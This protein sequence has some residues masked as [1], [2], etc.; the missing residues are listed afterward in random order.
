[1]PWVR[2]RSPAHL[3]PRVGVVRDGHIYAMAGVHDLTDLFGR[4]PEAER[5][6]LTRPSEVVPLAEPRL[7]P[8]LGRP[9]SIRDFYTFEQHVKTARRR[10]GLEMDPLWYD[11]PVFYFSNPSV[12]HGPYDEVTVPP[13]CDQLDYELEVAAVIGREGRDLTAEQGW[14]S[15]AGLLVFNDWSARDLQREEMRLHLGPAKGKD[16]ANTFGP[17]FVPVEELAEARG[18]RGWALEMSA[19]VNGRPYSSGRLDDM[20]W[21]FGEIVAY[22]S[23]GS[24]VLP[25]DLIGSGTCGTGCILELA[26]VHG[27]EAYP[28]LRP[29]DTVELTVDLLGTQR[30]TVT[31]G[32]SSGTTWRA[33]APTA[34]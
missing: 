14:E 5:M 29:G 19:R 10:R 33:T 15:I 34:H 28:W 4:F 6:A 25:G 9:P 18:E 17:F 11:L 16:F 24:R 20:H 27:S 3:A 23:R 21:S 7:L 32:G 22:A 26:L 31:V 1:M 30:S 12:C 2:Y 8:P 13:G